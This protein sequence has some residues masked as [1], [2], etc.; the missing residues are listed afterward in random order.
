MH[1][2]PPTPPVTRPVVG[3]AWWQV[4]GP[5]LAALIGLFMLTVIY[6]FDGMSALQRDLGLS[7]LGALVVG[8]VSFVV[9]AALTVP[10]G[11][12]LGGRAPTAVTIPAICF[13]FFGVLLVAFTNAGGLLAVGR[14]L[15]G[16]G[17]GA[18]TGATVAL[19]LKTRERRGVLAGVFAALAALALLLAPVIGQV[20]S[21]AVGFRVIQLAAIP[22]LLV[23]LV[24]S[25]VLGIV[26]L[27]A[28]KRQAP[29]I[30]NGMPYPP[31]GPT[32][33]TGGA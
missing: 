2:T 14:A 22:F 31:P 5:G 29:P 28:A 24:V 3:P 19:I 8:L 16:L 17:T 6:Q 18:A 20:I 21:E 25:A 7:D 30:P 12:L 15:Q 10:V 27:S 32:E 23:A 1:V 33:F 13:V 9:A 4:F 11:L 26:S